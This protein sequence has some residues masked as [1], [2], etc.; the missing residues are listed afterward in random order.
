MHQ[1]THTGMSYCLNSCCYVCRYPGIQCWS[2]AGAC[3]D[4]PGFLQ[5][6]GM[7]SLHL[8][9]RV[10]CL[11]SLSVPWPQVMELRQRQRADQ[12]HEAEQGPRQQQLLQREREVQREHMQLMQEAA[13]TAQTGLE[14]A[15]RER[16]AIK[17]QVGSPA[18]LLACLPLSSRQN[19]SSWLL[20]QWLGS[21]IRSGRKR[22]LQ[23]PGCVS[24]SLLRPAVWHECAAHSSAVPNTWQGSWLHLRQS[25]T[26]QKRAPFLA[27]SVP[28]SPQ[29]GLTLCMPVP[30]CTQPAVVCA[31]PYMAGAP[32]AASQLPS[33]WFVDVV[34]AEGDAAAH[35]QQVAQLTGACADLQQQLQVAQEA[36]Q[37]GCQAAQHQVS[38]Q[39]HNLRLHSCRWGITAWMLSLIQV[40]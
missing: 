15:Q 12:R 9:C 18:C 23:W 2:C 3:R 11:L 35:S 40:S 19:A 7:L 13:R 27:V 36:L 30:A 32:E 33:D 37:E 25:V 20:R 22:W 6:Y 29:P 24:C 39:H 26:L 31:L 4:G 14:K 8:P 10:S 34:Q 16:D 21:A 5:S 28:L 1:W 17:R 38:H